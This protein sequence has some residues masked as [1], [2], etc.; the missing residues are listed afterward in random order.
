M[1]FGPRS[2]P[3]AA[4]TMRWPLSLRPATEP[5]LGAIRLAWWRERLEELDAGKRRRRS[6]ACRLPRRALAAR[7]K[8]EELSELEDAWLPLFDAFPGQSA[9]GQ[10]AFA[11]PHPVRH[12]CAPVE[13][14]DDV[15]GEEN[16]G[17]WHDG[18]RYCSDSVL[19]P[20]FLLGEARKAI[21]TS[22]QRGRRKALRRLTSLAAIA[23]RDVIRAKPLA[24][25][26]AP[27]RSRHGGIPMTG[28]LPRG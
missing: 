5:A 18:A 26:P 28:V 22:R 17:R 7:H 24:L 25:A 2:L 27:C 19:P 21:A 16:F 20:M 9:G 3:F 15:E 1:G 11:R 13:A 8:G 14:T 4:L 10:T 23:A 6:P 12:W